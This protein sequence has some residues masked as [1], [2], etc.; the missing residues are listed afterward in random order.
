M[1]ILGEN[2]VYMLDRENNVFAV[3]G[4]RFVDRK[5]LDSYLHETLMVGVSMS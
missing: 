1:V 4:L 2:R 5:N 3:S